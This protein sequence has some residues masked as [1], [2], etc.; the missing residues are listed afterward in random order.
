MHGFDS[1]QHV[2]LLLF[3]FFK[4]GLRL[5]VMPVVVWDDVDFVSK[6]SYSR[7]GVGPGSVTLALRGLLEDDMDPRCES[8]QHTEV[9]YGALTGSYE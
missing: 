2:V 6:V 3:C 5:Q 7:I 1:M 4:G 9:P 8:G